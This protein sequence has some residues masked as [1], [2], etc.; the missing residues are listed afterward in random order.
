MDTYLEVGQ[1]KIFA[2]A[3]EWPGW[4]RSGKDE[5]SALQALLEAGPRYGR[6]VGRSRLGFRAPDEVSDFVVVERLKGDSATD[7]GVPGVA[8]AADE[9]PVDE[10]E[11]KRLT[12][13]L[14]ACWRA[15]DAAV[16]AAAGKQLRLGPR[17]G[18]RQVDGVLEHVLGADQGYL[19]QLGWAYSVD[20]EADTAEQ[21][22]QTRQAVL[23]ALGPAARG[24]LPEFGPRGGPRW[25]LRYYARRSAWHVLDHAWEIEDRIL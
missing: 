17:G 13:V 3:I 24:E 6:V 14:K 1:T 7:F 11:L 2:S 19:R 12:A 16:E 25:T 5:A 23:Q 8:P 21:L 22:R 15:L 20:K 10:A 4:A 18:G 9:R